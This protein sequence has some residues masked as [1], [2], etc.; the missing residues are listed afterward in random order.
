MYC[1]KGAIV[2]A[3]DRDGNSSLHVAARYGHEL[4]TDT[5]LMRGADPSK[6]VLQQYLY[7]VNHIAKKEFISENT[8]LVQIRLM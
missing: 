3:V 1:L 5:L 7:K 4:L 2:D 8:P 6:F